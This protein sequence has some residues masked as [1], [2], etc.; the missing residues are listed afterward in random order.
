[1]T[2]LQD[3]ILMLWLIEIRWQSSRTSENFLQGG[4][5]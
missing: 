3:F 2:D 4:S 1:M 5:Y